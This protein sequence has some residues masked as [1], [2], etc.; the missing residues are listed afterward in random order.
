MGDGAS[1]NRGVPYE[2]A[3]P[4]L[5]QG[6]P[7]LPVAPGGAPEVVLGVPLGSVFTRRSPRRSEEPA[8]RHRSCC[9]HT[10]V[11]PLLVNFSRTLMRAGSKD[12][13]QS[14]HLPST[15]LANC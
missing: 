7:T 4:L 3:I 15:S 8:S 5:Q 13:L 14:F 12:A 2:L 6:Y 1:E 9:T 10:V 11:A